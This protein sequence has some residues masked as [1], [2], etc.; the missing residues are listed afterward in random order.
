MQT[1]LPYPDFRQSAQA[2]DM[3]RL[4]KQRVEGYQILRTLLGISDGWKNHPA[5]KMWC[6]STLALW[7]YTHDIC[8]EW[9]ARGYKDTVLGKIMVLYDTVK[10]PK[11]V[12]PMPIWLGNEDFHRS[13]RANLVAKWPEFY[14]LKFGDI[15][16]EPYVWPSNDAPVIQR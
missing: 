15:P 4:G 9:I 3:R 12:H 11:S 13:H 2:L 14:S 1:F 7:V 6:G 5:T 16:F 8:Q 10:M